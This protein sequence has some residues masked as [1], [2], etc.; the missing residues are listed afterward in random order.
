MP[1]L[2]EP[3]DGSH[4]DLRAGELGVSDLGRHNAEDIDPGVRHRQTAQQK[5]HGKRVGAH[6]AQPGA[7]A[8][9]NLGPAAQEHRQ[10][11]ARLVPAEE[12]DMASRPAADGRS[13]SATPF[14][15]TSNGPSMNGSA[16]AL[17]GSDTAMR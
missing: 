6:Q 16:A 1:K 12:D 5:A 11:L 17:A 2:S 8:A 4:E 9:V 13:G 14:G 7:R 3:I 10:A 15:I